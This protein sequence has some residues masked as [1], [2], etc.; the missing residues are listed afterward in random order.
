[1]KRNWN[2]KMI[3]VMKFFF[4]CETFIA[5]DDYFLRSKQN[6]NIRSTGAT[7]SSLTMYEIFLDAYDVRKT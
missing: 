6:S 3:F 7:I 1:M 4:K 5:I 2:S